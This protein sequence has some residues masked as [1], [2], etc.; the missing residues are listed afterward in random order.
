MI[1]EVSLC[2]E[3]LVPTAHVC[4]LTRT[5]MLSLISHKSSGLVGCSSEG[6]KPRAS[7]FSQGSVLSFFG[8]VRPLWQR[9]ISNLACMLHPTD[10]LSA[11]TRPLCVSVSLLVIPRHS[12]LADQSLSALP[13]QAGGRRRF[14]PQFSLGGFS[15]NALSKQLT[16]PSSLSA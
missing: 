6:A 7:A 15:P 8:S 11:K 13:I 3:P 2:A 1:G 10:V 9:Q 12:F 5:L 16:F 4:I 14:A